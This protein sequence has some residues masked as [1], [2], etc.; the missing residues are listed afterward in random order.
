MENLSIAS[1][2]IKNQ[3]VISNKRSL[4]AITFFEFLIMLD[5]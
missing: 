4:Q 5:K 2:F 3:F 1:F